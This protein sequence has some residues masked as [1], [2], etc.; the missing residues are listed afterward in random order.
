M[1]RS[2]YQGEISNEDRYIERFTFIVGLDYR[3]HPGSEELTVTVK[4]P[5]FE[6]NLKHAKAPP[7]THPYT[8]WVLLDGAF[9]IPG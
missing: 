6:G 2:Y 8:V 3:I 4:K 1:G 7:P 9:Q 5:P